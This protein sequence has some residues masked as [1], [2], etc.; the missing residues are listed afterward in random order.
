MIYCAY[1]NLYFIELIENK[2]KDKDTDEDKDKDTA[3]DTDTVKQPN[4]IIPYEDK[5]KQKIKSMSNVFV[6]EESQISAYEDDERKNYI[7]LLQNE[8]DDLND[9]NNDDEDNDDDIQLKYTKAKAKANIKV[10]ERI[11]EIEKI[12][13]DDNIITEVARKN[14]HD[15]LVKEELK[16]LHKSY[17]IEYTP[18]GNVALYYDVERESFLYYSDKQ[19]PSPYLETVAR[20][21]VITNH[22][23]PIYV[24]IEAEVEKAKL[25][26]LTEKESQT[27][28]QTQTH[29][30]VFHTR[31]TQKPQQQQHSV[32]LK[33][34][35]NRFTRIG[36]F[37]CFNPLQPIKREETNSKL[38]CSYKDFKNKHSK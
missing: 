24:D 38:K 35:C 4:P 29:N 34:R 16:K 15:R 8:L 33:E 11:S 21:Y 22:C 9:D 32:I 1:E 12:L 17:V 3:K 5:Y 37:S 27:Q 28:T 23:V 6:F 13:L 26:L 14:V 2:N 31:S 20:K 19:I 30:K 7:E 18:V 10:K 25:K 36:T